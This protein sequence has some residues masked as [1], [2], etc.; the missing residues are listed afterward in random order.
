MG[1]RYNLGVAKRNVISGV[2]LM[3]A[4]MFQMLQLPVSKIDPSNGF[5]DAFEGI[6]NFI[7]WYLVPRT[8]RFS[9]HFLDNFHLHIYV[10]IFLGKSHST[11]ENVFKLTVLTHS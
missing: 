9:K 5:S 7:I 4:V 6:L 11:K 3:I 10:V 8:L 2:W 1:S